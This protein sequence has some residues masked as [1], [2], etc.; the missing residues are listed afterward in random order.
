MAP[1]VAYHIRSFEWARCRELDRRVGGRAAWSA[2]PHAAMSLDPRR[3]RLARRRRA[4]RPNWN[5]PCRCD[6]ERIGL[7]DRARQ[8]REG[9][10]CG[11]QTSPGPWRWLDLLHCT[12]YLIARIYLFSKFQNLI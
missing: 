3:R 10:L 2:P 4:R 9:A 11:F 6:T 12:L 7:L 8:L 5:P 1:Y